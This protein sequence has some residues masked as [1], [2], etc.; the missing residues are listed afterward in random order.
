MSGTFLW[1]L[2]AVEVAMVCKLYRRR[3]RGDSGVPMLRADNE[4]SAV[5]DRPACCVGRRRVV[6]TPVGT[7]QNTISSGNASVHYCGYTPLTVP[8]AGTFSFADCGSPAYDLT[9]A[10]TSYVPGEPDPWSPPFAGTSWIG[11]TGIDAPSNE[12]R[13]RVGSY[14]YVAPF[15]I[16]P[17]EEGGFSTVR[18]PP[19]S[20]PSC[21]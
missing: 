8:L 5:R 14:E 11:P 3:H 20:P 6:R 12:Y 19:P 13:A 21:I 2:Y 4:L 7:L 10:L 1:R 17:N 18:P 16:P 15:L 9:V